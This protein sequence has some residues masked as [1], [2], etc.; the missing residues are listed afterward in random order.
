M[1]LKSATFFTACFIYS[2]HLFASTNLCTITSDI[3]SNAAKLTYEVDENSQQ[4][5]HIY[6]ENYENNQMVSK[7]ELNVD[8]LTHGGI[9]LLKKDKNIVVRIWSDNF[10]KDLGGV[11]YLDTLY[12]GVNGERRQYEIDL[13]KSKDGLVL[14]SNKVDFTKMK[15]IA[16]RSK[17]FGVIGIEKILYSN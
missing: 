11:M 1:Q 5:T 3:D 8:A 16:K 17:L 10:D 7:D 2:F 14:S 4:I 12:N 9:V 6:Q 13:A 15:F